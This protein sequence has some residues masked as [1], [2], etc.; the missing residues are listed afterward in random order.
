VWLI[1]T[2]FFSLSWWFL[3]AR[4]EIVFGFVEMQPWI[5]FQFVEIHL[6]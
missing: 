3:V 5:F 2:S 4:D 6:T 1:A